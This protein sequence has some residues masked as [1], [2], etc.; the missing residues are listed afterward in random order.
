MK[1]SKK[2]VLA[3]V[4]VA[5]VGSGIG[6]GA[7]LFQILS[8]TAPE[9]NYWV[10]PGA[11]VNI[12]ESQMIKFGV[13]GDIGEITGDGFWE[14]AWMAAYEINQAGGI[15]VNGTTYYF[16][17][18]YEDTNEVDI[19]FVTTEGVAAVER[20]VYDK[21]IQFALGGFKSEAVIAYQEILMDNQIIFLG[22]GFTTDIYCQKVQDW[23]ERYK[24]FFRVMPINATSLAVETFDF[25]A[26]IGGYLNVTRV[27]ILYEDLTWT[28]SMVKALKDFLPYYGFDPIIGGL[29][30]PFALEDSLS[31]AQMGA[32]LNTLWGAG[33]QL[34]I[35]LISQQGGITMSTQ[36][37]VIQPNFA[38]VGIDVMAQLPSYWNDTGGACEYETI[39]MSTV[40]T[41]KT[42]STIAFWD[43]FVAMWGHD[44][45]YTAIGTYDSIYIYRDVINNS[46]SFNSDVIVNELEKFN[47]NN[48]RMGVSG[49]L[50]FTKSHDLIE[51]WPYAVT[52]WV[53]W[54]E[55][56]LNPGKGITFCVESGGSYPDSIAN[57]GPVELPPW[58]GPF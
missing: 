42:E 51:G 3:F 30:V 53:Q 17:L 43:R 58:V 35:P 39:M 44:P 41:N 10:I 34:V 15:V 23:Y 29:D 57:G 8:K 52:L 5:I 21:G 55:D 22:C 13:I 14:G 1:I 27:G 2:K 46:Q 28:K 32:H 24:Y 48:T 47:I 31:P 19:D 49:F 9:T 12:T 4:I 25:I 36:Y 16:A 11:P 40:R 18:T 45:L 6:I 37:A 38:L 54:R 7:F 33:A 56:P 20:L 50:A 26:Y